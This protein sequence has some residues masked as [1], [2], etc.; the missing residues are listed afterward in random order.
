MISR[1]NPFSLK[2]IATAMSTFRRKL[3]VCCA[4]MSFAAVPSVQADNLNPQDFHYLSDNHCMFRL[5]TNA[6][7]LLLPIEEREDMAHVKVIKNGQV[8]KELNCRLT[9]DKTDYM[10]PLSLKEFGNDLLIDVSFNNTADR[11]TKS[12]M[13]DFACWNQL[14]TSDSFDM[15]NR[16]KF[17][18]AYHHTPAYG[19]MNDPNGMFYKDGVWH[20]YF[21]HNPY[22][23][24][25]ENMTWGHSTSRDLVNWTFEGE[26]VEPDAIG[27]VFSGS[28]VVDKNNT[29]GFGAN[30]IV[31]MYTSAGQNQTQSLAY[32]TDGGKTFTKYANNPVITSNVPDFRDPHMFWNEDIQKWNLILA[33]GQKM[34]IY[35]SSNLKDWTFES[36]FGEGYGN[37]EGVW[38]CPDLL[39]MDNKWILICNINPGGPYGGSA[40]QYFVGTFDGH[41]F[42][43]ESKPEETKWMDW[44]KDHYATVTFDNAPEGR[45]VAVAWMSNWQYANIVPTK[46][47]RAA[48]TI[49]RDLGLFS[50]QGKSY[51]SVKA[52]KES[53]AAFST[54]AGTKLLPAC[55]VDVQLKNNATIVLSNSK[56]EQVTMTYDAA[57]ESFSMD[58]TKSGDTSF[59][60]AFAAVTK[61]PTYGKIRTLQIFI[62]HSSIETLDADGKMSM[63]NIVFPTE[64]YN[65]ITVKGG[66]YKV[67][68]LKK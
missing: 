41:Q 29:A 2:C 27:T 56:G 13:K 24:Q 21:Q 42:T 16:E 30:A 52:S 44:G 5:K 43:C 28:A 1:S 40:T 62:D 33:A 50:Y 31:A 23:S 37:H 66:K 58:R 65:K 46:Q 34:N 9:A 14:K 48:N 57:S 36:S 61:A 45:H 38:E 12:P 68:A 4:I 17:R 11:R 15:A 63:T 39:R 26:A 59:S 10:V 49:A 8:V 53:M 19:W 55:R 22:G 51:C 20:L 6:R 7:F 3:M 32:S 54:K 47:Y 35:T 64:P 67:Y 60:D 25:W 18:P